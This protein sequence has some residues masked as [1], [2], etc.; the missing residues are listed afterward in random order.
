VAL[1][2]RL[3]DHAR[4]T[5][6]LDLA[7]QENEDAATDDLVV[8]QS[9][10]LG[11]YFTFQIER[12]N[13]LNDLA[14]GVAVRYRVRA[15]LDDRLFEHVTLDVGFN[16]WP[17][18]KPE[19]LTGPDFFQFAGIQPIQVPALPLEQHVAEKLHAYTRDYGGRQSSRVKDLVDLLLISSAISLEA[20]RLRQAI[21]LTFRS[22]AAHDHPVRLP[23][24]PAIWETPFRNLA[25]EV[26]LDPDVN[27]GFRLAAEFLDPILDG[28]VPDA[29]RWDP[30]Q[31]FWQV[32][33]TQP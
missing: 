3:G 1:D 8:A 2:Y 4:A 9:T 21:Q 23:P 15:I 7:R 25:A 11:D 20:G 30:H 5:M 29:A 31:G 22:R 10:D 26:D 18:L 17:D 32:P 27:V 12:T 33:R 24:P 13:R 28:S 14:E 16:N 19:V 6:D